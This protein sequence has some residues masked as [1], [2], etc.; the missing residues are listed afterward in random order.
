MPDET[1]SLLS[2]PQQQ[3]DSSTILHQQ[4]QRFVDGIGI[5]I[6]NIDSG[7][8]GMKVRVSEYSNRLIY[9]HNNHGRN[10]RWQIT[11]FIPQSDEADTDSL[12]K[13]MNI[14]LIQRGES[15]L[16]ASSY[17]AKNGN[18][19]L[20]RQDKDFNIYKAT[21]TNPYKT[22]DTLHWLAVSIPTATHVVRSY[23][24]KINIFAK[25]RSKKLTEIPSFWDM[26]VVGFFV[27]NEYGKE[28]K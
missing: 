10:D 8:T 7:D 14:E 23:K 12:V 13:K 5:V 26:A 24:F 27:T 25:Q 3:E 28:L 21:Y 11:F 4:L 6:G 15:R 16:K 19:T 17:F 9:E 2:H 1:D 20:L 22:S 18:A